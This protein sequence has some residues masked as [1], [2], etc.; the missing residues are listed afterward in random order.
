MNK[1][2]LYVSIITAAIIC[3][4][5]ATIYGMHINDNEPDKDPKIESL[6]TQHE[7]T[8]SLEGN[9][10]HGDTLTISGT[11]PQSNSSITGIIYHGG[12]NNPT[13]VTVFQLTS[14]DKG[15]YTHDVVVNDDYL[16]KQDGQY[17]IS[18]QNEGKYKEVQFHRN[19]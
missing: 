16:W 7:F 14:D 17:I 8:V 15:C 4:G 6:I 2:I 1:K 18:V 5:V 11:V 13:I 3:F 10:A 9:T 19:W 12:E